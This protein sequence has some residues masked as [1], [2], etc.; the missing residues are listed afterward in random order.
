MDVFSDF[1]PVAYRIRIGVTG[2]RQLPDPAGLESRVKQAIEP[3]VM[4]LFS[5]QSKSVIGEVKTK[6]RYT[7]VSPLAEGA[8]RVVARAVLAY[9]D[10]RL[11]AVLPLTLDDYLE[12]FETESSRHEFRSMLQRCRRPT[13]L[14]SV[15]IACQAKNEYEA[16]LLRKAAYEAV[17]HYVVDHSDVLIAI[18]DGLESRGRGGTK[19]IVDYAIAQRRPVLRIWHGCVESLERGDGLDASALRAMDR[20]NCLSTGEDDRKQSLRGLEQRLFKSPKSASDL[21]EDAKALVYSY[22]FPYYVQASAEAK[23]NQSKYYRAGWTVYLASALA[24]ASVT[25]AVLVPF[26]A[27]FCFGLEL[28]LLC[29][30]GY[31]HDRSHLWHQRWMESRFLAE[32]IRAGI[33]MA[34]CGV[35]TMPIE[36]LPFMGQAHTINDWMVRVFDEVWNRLPPLPGC[37]DDNCLVLNRYVREAWLEDQIGFHKRKAAREG[38]AWKRLEI[39][40]KVILPTTIAAAVMHLVFGILPEGNNVPEWAEHIL[41]FVALVFPA[42]AASIYGLDA[43][44]QHLRLEKRS[45]SLIPQLENLKRLMTSA[46]EPTRFEDLLHRVDDVMLRETQDWLMLVRYSSVKAG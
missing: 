36:V 1:Q 45:L 9:K 31:V 27:P 32:R 37:T 4:E 29:A 34:V 44:R 30:I 20:F 16:K 12:T 14:R 15:R 33:F 2:H 42:V 8:D 35:D 22:L 46:S 6:I 39:L 13:F 38:R 43:Q 18:W 25:V 26:I 3:Q 41:T 40:T 19:E 17:G 10:A 24:V 23:E 28:V 11:E 5:E 7:V 21:S